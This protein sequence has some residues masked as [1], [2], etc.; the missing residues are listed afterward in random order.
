MWL[1]PL[2]HSD[3]EKHAIAVIYLKVVL[4]HA[5]PLVEFRRSASIPPSN[6]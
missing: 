1:M 6:G 4:R 3:V 2:P 5:D